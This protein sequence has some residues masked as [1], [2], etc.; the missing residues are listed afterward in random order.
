[1]CGGTVKAGAGQLGQQGLSPR[2]RGNR[3]APVSRHPGRRSIPACAGEPAQGLNRLAQ[4][5]VY[6]RVC[7]GTA[8]AELLTPIT[9]GL[10]PR[11]RGNLDF[12]F[13]LVFVIRSIPACAGEPSTIGLD[14]FIV[15]VYPRVCG[16][17]VK[18]FAAH[19][20]PGGLSPRVRGNRPHC[21]PLAR[22]GRSI[23]ACAG[24]PPAQSPQPRP[25]AVYPR[26]CGG[27]DALNPPVNLADGLSPRVRG[28][29][30]FI[31]WEIN[32]NRSIPACAG[33]PRRSSGH[34]QRSEVYPRVCGGTSG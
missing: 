13:P 23:P 10:S 19:T 30:G 18:Q 17:T 32:G 1:M 15:K 28:N 29:Q 5:Q 25:V 12:L 2:V 14:R 4:A 34:R 22:R 26:V 3:Y 21:R 9:G 24:E 31:L 16:G 27:T 11:V 7:G 33:E 6:P 20:P 8:V